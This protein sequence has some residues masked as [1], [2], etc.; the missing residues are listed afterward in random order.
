MGASELSTADQH[1][2]TVLNQVVST[3]SVLGAT[4]IITSYLLFPN[5]RKF[6]YKLVLWLSVSDMFN[7]G[8][9]YFGNPNNDQVPCTMQA[10]GI[11][12]FSVA[13][14]LWSGAIA[15]VLRSTVIDKRSDIE[16]TYGK[17]HGIVW[18][19]AT[20]AAIVPSWA[21]GPTGAW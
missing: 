20:L 15:Y 1:V 5:L 17:M 18:S 11:Q 19:L 9:S 21:Y 13:S 10:L 12:F 6:S 16:G 2:L 8:C 4:L 7:Q 3:F 14:F